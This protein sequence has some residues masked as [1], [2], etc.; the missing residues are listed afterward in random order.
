MD[1]GTPLNPDPDLQHCSKKKLDGV[2][3]SFLNAVVFCFIRFFFQTESAIE[4]YER[5][6]RIVPEHK[7]A[8]DSILFLRGRPKAKITRSNYIAFPHL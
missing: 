8:L 4:T 3:Y 5:I 2:F 6:L 7:E 1:P